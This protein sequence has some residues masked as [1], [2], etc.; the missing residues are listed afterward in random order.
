MAEPV[1]AAV[2]AAI[3]D[4]FR[5]ALL[6][7]LERRPSTPAELAA[8]T[9]AREPLVERALGVLYDAGLVTTSSADRRFR[10]TGRGWSDVAGA[11]ILLDRASRPAEDP[12]QDE[13]EDA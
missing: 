1:S 11:L 2:F 8:V 7:A 10:T 12:A 13:P 3:S 4:P 6:V 5:L 9:S